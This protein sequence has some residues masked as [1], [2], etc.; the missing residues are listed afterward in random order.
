MY[1]YFFLKYHINNLLS[2]FFNF[3]F[4]LN[5]P[6]PKIDYY[7]YMKM[8]KYAVKQADCKYEMYQFRKGNQNGSK[9]NV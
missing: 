7:F 3:L 4:M 1:Y 2:N 8:V 9:K 6:F 5:F